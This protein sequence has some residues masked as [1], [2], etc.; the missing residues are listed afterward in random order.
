MNREDF[1]HRRA[2]RGFGS[3]RLELMNKLWEV[4]NDITHY[5]IM[6]EAGEKFDAPKKRAQAEKDRDSIVAELLQ[7][8]HEP[9]GNA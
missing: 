7:I 1:R 4:N 9:N 8:T 2:K 5:I 3:R 6:G